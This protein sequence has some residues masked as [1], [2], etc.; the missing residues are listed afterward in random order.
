MEFAFLLFLSDS[1]GVGEVVG[2]C[3]AGLR[4]LVDGGMIRGEDV[5]DKRSGIGSRG[6][7]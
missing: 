2:G 5:K 3:Y 4:L 1:M 6:M 7:G